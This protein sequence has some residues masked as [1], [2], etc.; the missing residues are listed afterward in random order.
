[1][2]LCGISIVFQTTVLNCYHIY[3]LRQIPRWLKMM[4]ACLSCT[5]PRLPKPCKDDVVPY[6]SDTGNPEADDNTVKVI[7]I[8]AKDTN[9]EPT[10]SERN[11]VPGSVERETKIRPDEEE[12]NLRDEWK[13]LARHFDLVLFF[14]FATIHLFLILFI[15]VVMPNTWNGVFLK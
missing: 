10:N 2:C 7:H 1:M 15:F 12:E 11:T 3:P 14:V 9:V 13:K 4:Q 5:M 8:G 6:N